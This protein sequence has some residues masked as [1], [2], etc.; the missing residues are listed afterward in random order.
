MRALPRARPGA[1][2]QPALA[3]AQRYL[4]SVERRALRDPW[5]THPILLIVTPCQV[6]AARHRVQ[7]LER[8]VRDES[9]PSEQLALF[10]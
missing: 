2:L 5:A 10:T 7:I 1:H 4:L 3:R 9:A 8:R 6:K